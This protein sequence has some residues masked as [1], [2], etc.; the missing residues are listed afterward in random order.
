MYNKF[1]TL[2]NPGSLIVHIHPAESEGDP[3]QNILCK[4]QIM[5]FIYTL[6][7]AYGAL[8]D[9]D[10]ALGGPADGLDGFGRTIT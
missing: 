10:P 8:Y 2:A 9:E 7:V 5:C 6:N 3:L 4:I 1:N